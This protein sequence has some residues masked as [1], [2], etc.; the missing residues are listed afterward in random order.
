MTEAQ[1][2]CMYMCVCMYVHTYP[3]YLYIHKCTCITSM[4]ANVY[5]HMCVHAHAHAGTHTGSLEPTL[6]NLAP[7]SIYWVCL[8]SLTSQRNHCLLF[9]LLSLDH[10]RGHNTRQSLTF[11]A[12]LATRP[13]SR[14]H[15]ETPE[16]RPKACGQ[17][18]LPQHRSGQP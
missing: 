2:V 13:F 7:I 4:Q 6:P 16:L 1:A 15:P 18:L 17:G 12:P 11:K 9:L 14:G 10:T 5:T 8:S 3:V